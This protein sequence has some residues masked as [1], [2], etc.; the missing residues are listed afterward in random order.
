MHDASVMGLPNMR[1]KQ[2][3]A[4]AATV[5][6]FTVGGQCTPTSMFHIYD[7]QDPVSYNIR[8][9]IKEWFTFWEQQPQYQARV[10]IGWAAALN[11][12]NMIRARTQWRPVTGPMGA[13]I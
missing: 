2:E 1:V 4:T 7:T 11:K 8:R 12:I 10:R 3:R 13:L 9:Q 6:G 5:A